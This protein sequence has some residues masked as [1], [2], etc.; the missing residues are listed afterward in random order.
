MTYKEFIDLNWVSDIDN[1]L[2]G[3]TSVYIVKV[4]YPEGLEHNKIGKLR[5]VRQWEYIE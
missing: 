3:G 1:S 2:D 4:Y 5:I